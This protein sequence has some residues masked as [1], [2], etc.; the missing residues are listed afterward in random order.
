MNKTPEELAVLVKAK[1]VGALAPFIQARRGMLLGFIEKQLGPA[2]R[3]KV[4]PEDI[5]Q[6][7]CAEAVRSFPGADFSYREPFS[8]LCQLA[9]R[10]IIDLHRR[11]FDAQKRDA[12]KEVSID[13]G[14]ASNDGEGGLI[15]LLVA[16]MTSASQAFSRNAREARLYNALQSLPEEQRTALQLRYVENRPSKDIAQRMG[17]SDASIRVMLSRSLKKLQ[18]LLLEE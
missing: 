9:E 11:F 2:L 4:E 6:D 18:E 16:S 7:T 17:K 5:F 10:R 1:D 13:G 8:W 12:G 14:G 15:N 3:T